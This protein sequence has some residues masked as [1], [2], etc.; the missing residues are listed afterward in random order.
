MGIA[1][2]ARWHRRYATQCSRRQTA[3]PVA[4]L[5]HRV[6]MTSPL[7]QL[8]LRGKGERN[9]VHS[10]KSGDWI[11]G[12]VKDLSA[13]AESDVAEAERSGLVVGAGISVLAGAHEE[14]EANPDDICN[15]LFFGVPV[16]VVL[17]DVVEDCDGEG[18]DALW[19]RV[20][21]SVAA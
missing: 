13:V 7:T 2:G 9:M 8:F 15:A 6:P 19:R 14:V 21:L 10:G 12:R 1:A 20:L 18:F 4:C 3:H 5:L 16:D 11:T 17:E